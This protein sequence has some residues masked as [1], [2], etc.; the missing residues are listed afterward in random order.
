MSDPQNAV[1]KPRKW[2]RWLRLLAATLALLLACLIILSFYLYH[3]LTDVVVW[4]ANRSQPGMALE[5]QRAEFTSGSRIEFQNLTLKTGRQSD[6]ALRIEKAV[7]DFTWNDLRNHRIASIQVENPSISIT[8]ALLNS[9]AQTPAGKAKVTSADGLWLVDEFKISG[10]SAEIDVSHSPLIRFAFASDLHE[11][12]LS[13]EIKLSTQ[14]QSLN[15]S[16]IEFLSRDPK[17]VEFGTI[18]SIA[19]NFSL[20]HIAQNK[21][22]GLTI[23]TPSLSLTPGLLETLSTAT[24]GTVVVNSGTNAVPGTPWSI[25]KLHLSDGNFFVKGF[26]NQIPETSMKF[27]MDEENLLLGV[28]SDASSEVPH[29]IQIWDIRGAAAFARLQPFLWVGSAEV[30]FTANGLFQRGE[31]EAV[32][33]TEMDLQLGQTFRSLLAATAPPKSNT[34]SPAAQ[35][36]SDSKPWVIRNLHIIN[37]R[38]TMVDLGPELPNI[39]FKLDTDMNNVALSDEIGHADTKVQEVVISDLTIPSPLDPFVPVLNFATIRLRFSLAQILDQQI[40]QVVL[41][42]P[43]IFV[44]EQLFWYADVLKRRQTA[45]PAAT[46]QSAPQPD[47]PPHSWSI[48][49][50]QVTEGSLVLANAGKEG[51]TMPFKFS[52]EAKNLHFNNLSDLQLKVRLQIQ[53]ADYPFPSYQLLLK[54]LEGNIDFGLPPDTNA[55]NLVQTLYA[56]GARWRQFDASQLWLSVTYDSN[57]IYGNRRCRGLPRISHRRF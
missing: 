11:I 12:Y 39:G 27:A 31:L 38:A 57:G 24:S 17:P 50:L 6:P 51:V 22:D 5:L 7:I 21:I 43:S 14:S 18:K 42:K 29:K 44:G 40:D 19:I 36:G 8:D 4:F 37:G 52:S 35:A 23:A 47:A 56:S 10:G 33:I 55:R 16:R 3:N 53:K 20:N 26:G 48:N 2:L 54:Q 28:N 13:S 32:T 46:P 9:P 49:E 30:D 1:R 25:G 41:E 45:V 15:I 34:A